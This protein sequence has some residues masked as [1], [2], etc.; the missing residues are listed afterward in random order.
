MDKN[1]QK[2]EIF[3]NSAEHFLNNESRYAFYKVILGAK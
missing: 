2:N 1:L 3:L